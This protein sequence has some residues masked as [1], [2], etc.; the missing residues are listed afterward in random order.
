MKKT[1]F[2]FTM[3]LLGLSTIL[4][5]SIIYANESTDLY[6]EANRSVGNDVKLSPEQQKILDNMENK[7]KEYLRYG[8]SAPVKSDKKDFSRSSLGSW[9]WRDGLICVTDEGI[10]TRH[11][12]TWHAA[13]VCPQITEGVVEAAGINEGVRYREGIWGSNSYTVWQIGVNDTSVQQ[14]W[15]AGNWAGDQWGKPYNIMFWNTKQT[16]SFYCSQL[17]WAAYYY[18]AGVD[19]NKID[20]DLGPAIAVH[21][22][23]FVSNPK[24]TILY[25]NR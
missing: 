1:V 21:P 15:Y 7:E 25:R 8:L 6:I 19:L 14:D 5:S 11:I 4:N 10:G 20:N 23:E 9:S 24:T 12:N 13:I 17:V 2:L 22:G 3:S 16:D 18:T